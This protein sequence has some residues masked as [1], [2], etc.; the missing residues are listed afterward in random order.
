MLLVKPNNLSLIDDRA[1]RRQLAALLKRIQRLRKHEL[2]RGAIGVLELLGKQTYLTEVE[3]GIL[4][5]LENF[6]G[7]V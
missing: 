5:W 6:Y 7:V 1:V 2:D 3:E 4:S